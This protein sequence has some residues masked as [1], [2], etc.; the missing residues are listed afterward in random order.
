MSVNQIHYGRYLE[1]KVLL[2]PLY[3]RPTVVLIVKD[4]DGELEEV[5]VDNYIADIAN[6]VFDVESILP[7]GT[8]LAIKVRI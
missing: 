3:A 1:C 7:I 8:K 4:S 6:I 5:F 2:E